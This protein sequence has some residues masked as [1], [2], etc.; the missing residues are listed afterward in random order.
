MFKNFTKRYTNADIKI[1]YLCLHIKINRVYE[2]FFKHNAAWK[3]SK[4]GAFSGPYFPIFRMN[5]GK[6]RPE[7]TPWLGTFYAVYRKYRIC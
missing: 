3:L 7:K 2:M 6:Y 4:Y 1:Q 5:A